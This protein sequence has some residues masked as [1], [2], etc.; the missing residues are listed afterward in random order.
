MSSSRGNTAGPK[1]SVP[2]VL[3]LHGGAYWELMGDVRTF[4]LHSSNFEV[5]LDSRN[6]CLTLLAAVIN[7]IGLLNLE[8]VQR[9]YK[10]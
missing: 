6:D 5:P 2:G 3:H 10:C 8:V 9:K 7:V 4:H 1:R